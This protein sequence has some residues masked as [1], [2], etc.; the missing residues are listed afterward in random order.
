MPNWITHVLDV[1]PAPSM[2]TASSSTGL[3]IWAGPREGWQSARAFSTH[4]APTPGAP[5]LRKTGQPMGAPL[6]EILDVRV[7]YGPRVVLDGIDWAIRPGERWHLTGGNGSG[8]TTLLALLS[9]KHPRSYAQ[10]GLRLW[11]R[12]QNAFSARY[13]RH[14]VG[15][16][17]PEIANALP[18]V[19]GRSV[20]DVVGTGFEGA[21]VLTGKDGVGHVEGAERDERVQGIWE[22]LAALDPAA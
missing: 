11:G 7:S 9:G 22:V 1:D 20:Q 14:R 16:V 15:V 12:R 6:A 19:V 21:F 2:A 3:G 13:L 17:S 4:V 5:L 18:R 10:K 8:K